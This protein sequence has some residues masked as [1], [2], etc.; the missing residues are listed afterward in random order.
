MVGGEE[1]RGTTRTMGMVHTGIATTRTMSTGA[2]AGIRSPVY[3][4]A[5]LQ[6]T[7]LGTR[8]PVAGPAM[9]VENVRAVEADMLAAVDMVVAV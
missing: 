8:V 2:M 7:R 1:V 4:A 3:L 9:A 6:L 5:I